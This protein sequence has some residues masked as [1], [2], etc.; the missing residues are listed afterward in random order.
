MADKRDRDYRIRVRKIRQGKQERF[1]TNKNALDL[2]KT[3]EEKKDREGKAEEEK[4]RKEEVDAVNFLEDKKIIAAIGEELAKEFCEKRGKVEKGHE[5]AIDFH[6]LGLVAQVVVTEIIN[7][8]SK[9]KMVCEING[10]EILIDLSG[11][12]K[13]LKKMR[14]CNL[15]EQDCKNC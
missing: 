10:K 6:S 15:D 2:K 1:G 13:A 9:L 14:N 3:A 5:I 7:R 11:Y 8:T 12:I 4:K